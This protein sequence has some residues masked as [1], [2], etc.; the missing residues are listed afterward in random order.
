M[1]DVLERSFLADKQ[2]VLCLIFLSVYHLH[3]WKSTLYIL[4]VFWLYSGFYVLVN[5]KKR[6]E[7]N[8][9]IKY[10]FYIH[11]YTNFIYYIYTDILLWTIKCFLFIITLINLMTHYI[12]LLNMGIYNTMAKTIHWKQINPDTPSNIRI[13]S[14]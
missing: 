2:D 12:K 5:T 6:Y 9:K 8:C 7:Q 11:I 4:S 3:I 14:R 1:F 13:A 10:I